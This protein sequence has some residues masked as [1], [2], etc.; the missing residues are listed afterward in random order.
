LRYGIENL[1]IAGDRSEGRSWMARQEPGFDPWSGLVASG[2]P[3][4]YPA[5][6]RASDAPA[7][8]IAKRRR[9]ARVGGEKQLIDI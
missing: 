9:T 1:K 2:D 7:A 4:R 8:E 5:E 3:K 6:K